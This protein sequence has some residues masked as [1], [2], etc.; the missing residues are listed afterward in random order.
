MAQRRK[1]TPKSQKQISQEQIAPYD[2]SR[3][4]PNISIG[5]KKKRAEQVSFK[6]DTIKP[7]VLGLEDIDGAVLYY[8]NEII[9]PSVIQNDI[10][11]P[12]PV[13]YGNPEKWKTMQVDGFFRDK[14]N[15]ILA[16]IIVFK[17]DDLTSNTSIG[18]KIDANNPHMYSTFTKS[19]SKKNTYDN[20]NVLNNQ[21][22]I[23]EHY[24]VVIPDYVTINYSCVIYT[25]YVEQMNKII[26][27]INYA[28]NSYWG[29]PA[30]FKFNAKISSFTTAVEIQNGQDRMVKSTFTIKLYGYIIPDV[31]QKDMKAVKKVNSIT[32]ITFGVETIQNINKPLL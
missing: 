5:D 25:N 3:G 30:R 14:S 31:L 16:P 23:S 32:K 11:I 26:E 20:F 24:N 28:S 18:N 27:A 4:N 13:L 6:N 17:R 15:K 8:F 1:P 7:L 29:D 2:E 12:V 22:P 19:Y 10:R 21:K 9:K